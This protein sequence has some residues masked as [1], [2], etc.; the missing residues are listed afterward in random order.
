MKLFPSIRLSRNNLI[1]MLTVLFGSLLYYYLMVVVNE[2]SAISLLESNGYLNVANFKFYLNNKNESFS[3]VPFNNTTK[4]HSQ[5]AFTTKTT[6]TTK[7]TKTTTLTASKNDSFNSSQTCPMIPPNLGK[8]KTNIT[9][10][11]LKAH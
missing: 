9:G 6:K 2:E 3:T 10:F 7:S 11:T 5:T 8:F 4:N 1:L